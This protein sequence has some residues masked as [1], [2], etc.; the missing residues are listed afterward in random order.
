MS[1]H[2]RGNPRA[3][4]ASAAG[5]RPA[6]PPLVAAILALAGPAAGDVPAST[7]ANLR[8]AHATDVNAQARYAAFAGAAEREGYLQVARLFRAAARSEQVRAS[9]HARAIRL[10]GASPAAAA[11]AFQVKDTRQNL[12][13]ALAIEGAEHRRDYP[14]F[15]QQARRDGAAEAALGFTLAHR[16][17]A[18]LA[19]LYQDAVGRLEAMR[20]RGE[21]LH[22]CAVCGHVARG[23]PPALCPVSLSPGEAFERIP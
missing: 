1:A 17:E 2:D 16:A 18:E 6:L 8:L 10:L 5:V 9:V 13:S 21:E 19:R 3:P 11:Q 12:V 4:E 20:D 23:P 7:L 15:A 22:V 14:R